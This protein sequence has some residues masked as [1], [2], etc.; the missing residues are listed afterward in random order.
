MSEDV[1]PCGLGDK[2]SANVCPCACRKRSL[3]KGYNCPSHQLTEYMALLHAVRRMSLDSWALG[4]P[5]SGNILFQRRISYIFRT[6]GIP[7]GRS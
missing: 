5:G 1:C 7:E 6:N 3:T 4:C 2:N